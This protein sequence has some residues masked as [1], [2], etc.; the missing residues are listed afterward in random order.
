MSKKRLNDK[1]V[2]IGIMV[3]LFVM[4]IAMLVIFAIWGH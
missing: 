4:I 2:P 3:A 1:V